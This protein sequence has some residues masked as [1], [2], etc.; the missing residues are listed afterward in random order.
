M[1]V[2]KTY[3]SATLVNDDFVYCYKNMAGDDTNWKKGEWD[4]PNG[5]LSIKTLY[6]TNMD[7]F[8]PVGTVDVTDRAI[9]AEDAEKQFFD[10]YKKKIADTKIQIKEKVIDGKMEVEMEAKDIMITNT[11]GGVE[12]FNTPC[13]QAS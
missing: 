10:S 6:P 8:C 5:Q 11:E 3:N 2:P 12:L 7:C 4:D 1:G 13:D 9:V